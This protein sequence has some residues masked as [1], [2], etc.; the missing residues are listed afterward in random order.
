MADADLPE[1]E[2]ETIPR[3]SETGAKTKVERIAQ[4][5]RESIIAGRLERGAKLKQS[6]LA[7]RFDTS[8]TP[9]REALKILEAEG[10]V[11]GVS[12]RSAVV[13]PFDLQSAEEFVELR[14]LLESRLALA[15]MRRMSEDQLAKVRELHAQLEEDVKRGDRDSVR[16]NN[17]R[18]HQYLYSIAGQPQTL[19]FVH[20]LWARYP[21]DLIN[22]LE[23]RIAVTADEHAEIVRALVMK[24]EVGLLRAM[25]EHIHSGWRQLKAHLENESPSAPETA[26]AGSG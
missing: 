12:H 18:F 1:R 13:A 6:E 25:G 4:Y 10:Y 7:A 3:A 20:I 19:R 24:D 5:L 21:F 14:G 17:F 23:G 9:V 26:P 8:P 11:L 16:L 15:A 2:A 22:R